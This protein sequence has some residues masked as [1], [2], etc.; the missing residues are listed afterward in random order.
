M[1]GLPLPQL[2]TMFAAVIVI[3]GLF[4]SG[5]NRRP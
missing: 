4:K 1:K 3:F 5:P 2:L